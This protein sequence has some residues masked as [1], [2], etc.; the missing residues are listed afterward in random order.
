MKNKKENSQNQKEKEQKEKVEK[1]IQK[2]LENFK[3][4][5]NYAVFERLKEK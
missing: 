1:L 5:E 3:K 4:T 2:V